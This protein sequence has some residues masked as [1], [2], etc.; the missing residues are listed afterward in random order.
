M[1]ISFTKNTQPIAPAIWQPAISTELY[2]QGISNQAKKAETQSLIDSQRYSDFMGIQA[3]APQDEEQLQKVKEAYEQEV[4]GLKMGDLTNPQTRSQL[5]QIQNKYSNLLIESGIPQRTAKYQKD[6]KDVKDLEAKNKFVPAWKMKPILEAQKYIQDGNFYKDA[7]FTGEIQAGFD[8]YNHNK[9]LISTTPEYHELKKGK[10]T[11][12]LYQGKTYNSLYGKFMEGLNQPGALD[13]LYQQF[14]YTYGNED[15]ATQDYNTAVEQVNRLSNIIQTSNNPLLVEQA[16]KDLDYWDDFTKSVNPQISKEDAF[17]RYIKANAEDFARTNTNYALKESK[18]SDANKMYQEHSYRM[19]EIGAREAAALNKLKEKATI[20]NKVQNAVRI[21][22]LKLASDLDLDIYDKNSPD[23][24]VSDEVL[25][26]YGLNKKEKK[27]EEEDKT[28][29]VVKD[30][31]YTKA[32]IKANIGA[33]NKEFIKSVLDSYADGVEGSDIKIDGNNIHYDN[34]DIL[35]TPG[36]FDK[37]ITKEELLKK[38]GLDDTQID[39]D[40]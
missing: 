38:M 11:N 6:V 24:Y 10:Q 40:I 14:E 22:R 13:D 23:G 12:D 5:S 1:S 32:E 28:K 16:E 21:D 19:K 2:A 39:A 8:W 37:T 18:M 17:Q 27:E 26:S 4:S 31:Q 25:D 36:V 15:Y 7:R 20:D 3:I 30:K 33:G 29:Y 9:N 35:G 34:K